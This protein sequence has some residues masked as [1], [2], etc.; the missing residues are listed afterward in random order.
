[1]IFPTDMH[2][3]LAV[4][5]MN[6][7]PVNAISPDFIAELHQLA[8]S[9]G[10]NDAVR[11]VLFRSA[12]PGRYI[13]GADLA[14]VLQEDSEEAMPDRLRRLNR[15]WRRAFYALERIPQ[16]TVAAINGHCLGGGL[17]FALCC[18]YRLMIDDDKALVGLTETNVGLFPGAGGTYRLPRIVGLA[19]AKDMIFRA[20][21][22]KAHE[23]LAIGLVHQTFGPAEFDEQALAF[24]AQLAQGP[25]QAL[26]A[27]KLAILAGLTDQALSDRL[28]EDGFV[29]I[30]Q[31]ADAMEG[32]TAFW[33]KRAPQ[34]KGR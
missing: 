14:G 25:T 6:R 20:R 32:L 29:E 3:G 2:N 31:T 8:D 15:E 4:V 24:A 10:R 17:E 23:A 13:A 19:K 34:F 28:E 12:I 7:P 21:R 27:A 9:L 16:P 18:D 11:A 26:K 1:M 5:T 22:L 30:A 33:E